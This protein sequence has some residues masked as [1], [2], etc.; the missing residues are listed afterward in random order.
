MRREGYEFCLGMPE[1]VVRDIEGVPHE[2]IEWV[3]I[4]IPEDC[5]GAITMSLGERG[6]ADDEDDRDWSGQDTP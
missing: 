6:G 3:V 5:V 1:V 2:P 4:D